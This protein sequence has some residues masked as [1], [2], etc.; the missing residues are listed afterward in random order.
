M[1]RSAWGGKKR[2]DTQIF[3]RQLP[4]SPAHR[5]TVGVN[6]LGSVLEVSALRPELGF[7]AVA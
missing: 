2:S 7:V 5:R 1:F 3:G 4:Q 6:Q